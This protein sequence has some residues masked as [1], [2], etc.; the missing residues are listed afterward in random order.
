MT[1]EKGAADIGPG[2]KPAAYSYVVAAVLCVV[3]TFN[4]IDRQFLSVLAQPIKAAL[5]LS[6]TQLGMLNGLMFAVFYT[7][8]GIPVAQLADRYNR[9]RIVA[10]ACALW[11]F[12]SA[13]CGLATGFAT[14]ALARIGVGVGEAGGSPPSYAIICDYFPPRARGVGLAI[15]SLGVP[16]GVMAGAAS[17][18]WIAAHYGWRWA[19][20]VL[21]AA[22]LVL[23]PLVPLLVREPVRGRLDGPA[24]AGD[25][26]RPPAL[27]EVLAVFAS[28]PPLMLT[29]LGAGLIA[30]VSYGLSSWAPAFLI[31]D[32]GMA[33]TQ[34]AG[35]YSVT[36]GVSIGVGTWFGGYAVDRL[37]ARRPWVYALGP[38]VASW[39]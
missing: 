6:D 17:G 18:G 33:L 35:W 14:L 38:G 13:A 15:Y 39:R 31:R 19:F 12:F 24:K 32:K 10:V 30:L 3:Y 37:G 7:V 8:C 4:F 26:D 27:R 23:A 36:A 34:I 16:F 9:V 1:Q 29:A 20:L 28:S 5:H 11:S 21:G 2:V 22:G 25:P